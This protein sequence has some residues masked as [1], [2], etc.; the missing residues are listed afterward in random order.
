MIDTFYAGLFEFLVFPATENKAA[1][2]EELIAVFCICC[3]LGRVSEMALDW[4]SK[5]LFLFA[6]P[7]R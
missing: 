5:S 6:E 3:D 1:R 4:I 7:A 2:A